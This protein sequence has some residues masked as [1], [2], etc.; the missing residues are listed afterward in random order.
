MGSRTN[1]DVLFGAG[2][3]Q[4]I[5]ARCIDV[6]RCGRV[7]ARIG[8][9]DLSHWIFA[10]R[11]ARP[12]PTSYVVARRIQVDPTQHTD[13]IGAWAEYSTV[14]AE[15]PPVQDGKSSRVQLP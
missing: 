10:A 5:P 13:V 8:F 11:G 7:A 4:R 1:T 9:I 14:L 6:R 15:H 3:H 12:E 2:A